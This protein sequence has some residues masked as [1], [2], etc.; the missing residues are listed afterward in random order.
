MAYSYA[1]KD[2]ATPVAVDELIDAARKAYKGNGVEAMHTIAEKFQGLAANRE[3]IR[4]ALIAELQRIAGERKLASF[5]PQSFII[6][7]A[8]PFSLRLNLWLPSVGSARKIEQ[9]ARIYSYEKAHDHNFSL[10][11][12]GARR[13]RLQNPRVRIRL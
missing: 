3:F 8:S 11:T 12:V 1:A 9:E 6:H 5:A 4:D 10:L 7:R 13:T 2:D